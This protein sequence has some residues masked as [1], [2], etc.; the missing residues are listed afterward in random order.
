MA[1]L[2]SASQCAFELWSSLLLITSRSLAANGDET[3]HV[4]ES[5]HE[6]TRAGVHAEAEIARQINGDPRQTRV[7]DGRTRD[8][9]RAGDTVDAHAGEEVDAVDRAMS[10]K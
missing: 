4:R 1:R 7:P 3:Q 5:E 8:V 9:A 2:I 10:T 6:H